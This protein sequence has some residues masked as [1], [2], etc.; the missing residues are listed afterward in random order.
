MSNLTQFGDDLRL[1]L[2]RLQ[3]CLNHLNSLFA[4]GTMPDQTK[5]KQRLDELNAMTMEFSGRAT[6][7]NQTLQTELEQQASLSPET[8]AR[9]VSRRQTAQLHAHADTI[10]Q[11]AA[12]AAELAALSTLQAERITMLAILAR[13]E[14]ISA[15]IQFGER[16]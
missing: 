2:N 1:H 12:H 16:R 9:W 8:I 5:F 11:L 13:Q 7:L 4:K 10:E 14:A 15:Q 3:A 6:E